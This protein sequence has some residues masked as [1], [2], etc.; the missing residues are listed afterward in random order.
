MERPRKSKRKLAPQKPNG[1]IIIIDKDGNLKD[2]THM[3]KPP[4]Y[5]LGYHK[6]LDGR[7]AWMLV[8]MGLVNIGLDTVRTIESYATKSD[9]RKA[10][11]YFME[12][13]QLKRHEP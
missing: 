2:I 11:L 4:T 13:N 9:A 8:P 5:S 10:A 1:P 7:Y 6:R 12:V 3:R